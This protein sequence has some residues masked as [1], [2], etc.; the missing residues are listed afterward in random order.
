M[1]AD[2]ARSTSAVFAHRVLEA[3]RDLIHWTVAVRHLCCSERYGAGESLLL[4]LDVPR[5]AR[6]EFP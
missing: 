6:Q 2:L 5:L 1:M 3:H 4:A